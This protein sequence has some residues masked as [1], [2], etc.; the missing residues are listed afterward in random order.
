MQQTTL[1]PMEALVYVAVTGIEARGETPYAAAIAKEAN[2][3]GDDLDTTLHDLVEKNLVRREDAPGGNV[4]FGP[5]WC[6][7]QPR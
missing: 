2:L 3:A 6:A 1:S 7:R 4:D 5:R